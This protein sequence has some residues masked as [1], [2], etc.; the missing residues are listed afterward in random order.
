MLTP[1]SLWR[2]EYIVQ[3]AVDALSAAMKTAIVANGGLG[4]IMSTHINALS[5]GRRANKRGCL[6][7]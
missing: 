5:S 6:A 3:N 7:V 2:Q 1:C 4:S